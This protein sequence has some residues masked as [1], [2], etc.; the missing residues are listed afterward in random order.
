MDLQ[1]HAP[2]PPRS[3]RVR[4]RTQHERLAKQAVG[5]LVISSACSRVATYPGAS[6]IL[7][8]RAPVGPVVG[9]GGHGSGEVRVGV[10][11]WRREGQGHGGA[12]RAQDALRDVLLEEV[13][14]G[15]LAQ[16]LAGWVR[17]GALQ[18]WY[19]GNGP[20]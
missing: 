12:E 2:S 1:R 10:V 9:V 19:G 4:C 18:R 8:P 6:R 11:G 17:R 20:E 7:T 3:R 5:A 15:G 16:R 14:R 13:G